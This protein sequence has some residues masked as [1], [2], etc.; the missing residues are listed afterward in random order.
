MRP[1]HDP[2]REEH[3]L[4]SVGGQAYDHLANDDPVHKSRR[5]LQILE[6]AALDSETAMET[7]LQQLLEAGE[8]LD[9]RLLVSLSETP[10]QR[11]LGIGI[12][13]PDIYAYDAPLE[14]VVR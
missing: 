7:S 9:F 6:W 10:A 8:S 12:P 1:E 3:V 2:N 4:G 5:Y 13:L 11:T 14:E